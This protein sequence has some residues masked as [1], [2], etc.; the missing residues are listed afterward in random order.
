MAEKSSFPKNPMSKTKSTVPTVNVNA[1]LSALSLVKQQNYLKKY[2]FDNVKTQFFRSNS[3]NELLLKLDSLNLN[4]ISFIKNEAQAIKDGKLIGFN[5]TAY[6]NTQKLKLPSIGSKF[7][8]ENQSFEELKKQ[9]FFLKESSANDKSSKSFSFECD[10]KNLLKV[11]LNNKRLALLIDQYESDFKEKDNIKKRKPKF[12]TGPKSDL[13]VTLKFDLIANVKCGSFGQ[14]S[15]VHSNAFK[16]LDK[17]NYFFM[18]K[19]GK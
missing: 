5:N 7:L 18:K 1:N 12:R 2:V 16:R 6:Y 10:L 3:E 8:I 14:S 11:S 15:L 13:A 4:K 19:L 9:V 17:K